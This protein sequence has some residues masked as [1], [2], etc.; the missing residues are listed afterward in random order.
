MKKDKQALL[1]AQPEMQS[2]HA[3]EQERGENTGTGSIYD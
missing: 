3:V 1:S 2:A